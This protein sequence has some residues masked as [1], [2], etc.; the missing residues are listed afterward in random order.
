MG[1]DKRLEY[2][3]SFES[4]YFF[5]LLYYA[6]TQYPIMGA[7]RYDHHEINT[8]WG[9]QS[10]DQIWLWLGF[11][12]W[13][14][15]VST[16][17]FQFTCFDTDLGSDFIEGFFF[18]FLFRFLFLFLWPRHK[19]D[20]CNTLFF[21][22]II[23]NNLILWAINQSYITCLPRRCLCCLLEN[24]WCLLE[25]TVWKL[26]NRLLCYSGKFFSSGSI[27]VDETMWNNLILWLLGCLTPIVMSYTREWINH[28][29]QRS[30]WSCQH[31]LKSQVLMM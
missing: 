1:R 9:N 28:Q 15:R 7:L 6:G 3:A 27:F 29:G 4:C 23:F 31:F 20:L 11:V 22:G 8:F 17:Y 13:D 10:L 21:W 24:I 14:S 19:S 16:F 5:R 25:H 30:T 2:A 26:T 18:P 12:T